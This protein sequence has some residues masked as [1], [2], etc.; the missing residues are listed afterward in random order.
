MS[1][2][3]CAFARM[4]TFV[5]GF[6]EQC[7]GFGDSV[8]QGSDASADGGDVLFVYSLSHWI[9]PLL[10][11]LVP[12][13]FQPAEGIIKASGGTGHVQAFHGVSFRVKATRSCGIICT[14]P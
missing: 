6:A 7:L 4:L 12:R 5:F 1:E 10:S 11:S 14:L 8:E 13:M 2:L 3:L 9:I